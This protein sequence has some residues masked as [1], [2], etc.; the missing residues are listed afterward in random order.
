MAYMVINYCAI[1]AFI[2]HT[3]PSITF[4]KF[5]FVQQRYSE[6]TVY[7]PSNSTSGFFSSSASLAVCDG[8]EPNVP[9]KPGGPSRS[10]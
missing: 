6:T 1:C 7:I 2:T 10:N 5:F 9:R 8:R 4:T 3:F